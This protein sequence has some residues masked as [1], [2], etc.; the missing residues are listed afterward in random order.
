MFSVLNLIGGIVEIL[1]YLLD[2]LF[3]LCLFGGV[4]IAVMVAVAIPYEPLRWIVAGAIVIA[5]F[6][7]GLRWDRAHR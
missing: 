5:G 4:A 6:I 2:W 7:V 3:S 1:G